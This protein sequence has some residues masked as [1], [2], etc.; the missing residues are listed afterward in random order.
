MENYLDMFKVNFN[1]EKK[2]T[3]LF[4]E[5]QKIGAGGGGQ[6]NTFF[7]L[8]SECIVFV[9]IQIDINYIYWVLAYIK[10]A[11]RAND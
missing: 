6:Q 5:F 8:I 2:K 4:L 10:L 9:S 3:T 1:F 11:L 7:C